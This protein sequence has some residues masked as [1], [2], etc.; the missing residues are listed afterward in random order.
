MDTL[1]FLPAARAGLAAFLILGLCSPVLGQKIPKQGPEAAPVNY[2]YF[3]PSGNP[4]TDLPYNAPCKECTEELSARTETT[5]SYKGTGKNAGLVYSQGGYMPINI[6]NA[7]GR[8]VPVDARL[9]PKGPGLFAA[10]D[11]HAPVSIDLGQG[12][13]IRNRLGEIRF[14][15]RPEL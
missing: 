7:A 1:S 2:T 3:S 5:R 10:E 11:Q 8:W 12:S 4:E 14:N 13:R 6:H 15:N 9:K